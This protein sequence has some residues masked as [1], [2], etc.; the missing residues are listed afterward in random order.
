MRV[1][2]TI[3]APIVLTLGTLGIAAGAVAPVVAS[4]AAP[5]VATA[6]PNSIIFSG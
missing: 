1:K 5:V 4:S 2:R 3:I 6:S